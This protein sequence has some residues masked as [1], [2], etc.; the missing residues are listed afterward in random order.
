MGRRLAHAVILRRPDTI[1]TA[2]FRA[3]EEVPEW[4]EALI[5]NPEAWADDADASG[6]A[7]SEADDAGE[8]IGAAESTDEKPADDEAAQAVAVP[9]LSGKGSG[10]EAWRAYALAN[11]LEADEEATRQEIIDGLKAEGIAVEAATE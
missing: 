9:P 3:G 6:S 7:E 1:E 2:A 5:T 11:G 8:E 4:A 10:I